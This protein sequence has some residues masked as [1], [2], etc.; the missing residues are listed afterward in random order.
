MK[1]AISLIQA[2][3]FIVSSFA[4]PDSNFKV[5]VD[6]AAF[7]L[8][9]TA[10]VSFESVNA[11]ELNVTEEEKKRCRDWYEENILTETNPAYNFKVGAKQLQNNT[12]D[13]IFDIGTESEEGAVYRGGKT[14][15]ITLSHKKSDLVA[16]VEATIYEDSASCDWTVFI[17]NTGDENSPTISKF[18]AADC[19]VPTGKKVDAYFSKGTEPA[20]EDFELLTCPVSLM[21]MKFT[22]NGGRTESFLPYFNLLGNDGGIVLATGWSGQWFT[23]LAQKTDGVRINVNQEKLKG[24]LAPDE[25]IRSPLI[26]L[27]FYNTD[28]ALKGFNSFRNFTI[29]CVYPEG[30]KQITTSGVG[31]EFPE[32]TIDSLIAT[33]ESIPDWFADAVDYYW[34]DAGWYPIN[35]SWDDSVGNWFVDPTKFDRGFKEVS[36]AAHEKGIGWLLWHEPERCAEGTEVYNEC[37]K[38]DGWLVEQDYER[39]MVNLANDDCLDYIT[40][41]MQ[42]SI[43][44]N[45]VDYLRIDSIPEPLPFWEK[46]DKRWEDGRTGMTENH[47]VTNFY[48][49]LDTLCSNNPGLLID[50]C[51]SGGKRLDIEMSRR[52]IPLWRSDYNCMDGEGKSKEDIIQTTQAQTYGI[53]F[54]LPYN[55]TCAYIDGEYADRTNIISCSQR[56][57]Y[58]DIRPYM[59]GNYYPLTYGG[60]DTSR[61]LAMQFDKDAAE[62][63]ALI[64]KRENVADNQYTLKL[65]GLDPEKTYELYSYDTPDLR[66]TLTGEKLMKDGYTITINETPKAVIMLYKAI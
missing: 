58:Q 48:L 19:V 25:S 13:W 66:V 49:M 6:R 65:N 62:G 18:F 11:D 60:L 63:M 5:W 35:T 64:Y 30:T 16:T 27:T 55:G 50:N 28:N 2:L 43:Y 7:D 61:Y 53:S 12:D 37:I 22:A 45:G 8:S 59:L 56:L 51:C 39:N 34:V 36:D 21:A 57:G 1:I 15:Y 44:A 33:I 32:S 54:W 52:S 3:L 9:G 23:S 29:D 40:G 41:I 4:V 38:H 17:K 26:S 47:Y 10:E 42:R 24:Y 20:A 14:T 31:V 46:A